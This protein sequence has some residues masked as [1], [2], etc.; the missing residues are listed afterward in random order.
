VILYDYLRVFKMKSGEN[1]KKAIIRTGESINE[2][3]KQSK[4]LK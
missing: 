2:E 4:A 1:K 3:R